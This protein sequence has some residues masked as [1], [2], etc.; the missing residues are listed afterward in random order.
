VLAGTGVDPSLPK[1]HLS[2]DLAKPL[3]AQQGAVSVT[4]DAPAK[5]AG[6]GAITL[7]FRPAVGGTKD[8]AIAFAS[9][10]RTAGFTVSAGD[11]Q[12][13]FGDRA[14]VAIQTGTTAGALVLTVELGGV[15][16]QQTVIIDP[17][18][19]IITSVLAVRPG[20]AIEI[21]VAG[22]D[23]TRTAGALTFTFFDAAGSAVPPGALRVDAAAVFAGYFAT[24]DGGVFSLKAAFPVTGDASLITGVE[25]QI[26]NSIGAT[27]TSRVSF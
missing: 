10:G 15:T 21:A 18:A 2:L 8:T 3:S 20:G 17:A 1:P 5:A 26:A 6:A 4:F 22:F 19:V 27:R 13:H 12:A 7:D 11:T 14:A 23:N 9:G 16:D 24:S 25:V